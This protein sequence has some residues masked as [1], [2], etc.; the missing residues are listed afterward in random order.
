MTQQLLER[1]P[2]PVR[3]ER[4]ELNEVRKF[5]LAGRAQEQPSL[6]AGNLSVRQRR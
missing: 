4:A 5:N 3:V 6:R 2:M 1:R